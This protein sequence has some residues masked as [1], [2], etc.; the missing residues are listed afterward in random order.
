[1][2][3]KLSPMMQHYLQTKQQNPDALL[4][5]RL[6]DFYELFFEDAKIA[7]R[8]LELTLTGR[9]CGLEERA[10]MAGVPW[11]SADSYIG[12]LVSKGYKVAICEQVEDPKDAK[13]LVKRELVRIITPG[14]VTEQSQL[15][16]KIASYLYAVYF[17]KNACAL[18][19]CDVSTGEFFVREAKGKRAFH[20]LLQ[21]TRPKEI[22]TNHKQW[23]R[24]YIDV[25]TT[26]KEEGFF[27]L[28][29]CKK[30]L[31]QHFK[32][33][34]I[35]DIGLSS[36]NKNALI[37]AGAL[38]SYLQE[39]QKNSLSHITRLSLQE[40]DFAMPLDAATIRNLEL[41]EG[42]SGGK[43]S[44]LWVLDHCVTAMGA[45]MLRRMVEQPLVKKS[46]IDERL[47]AL[48]VFCDNF[49][50]LSELREDLKQ[51]YDLERLLS[52][53][54]Y[55]SFHARDCLSLKRSLYQVPKLREKISSMEV[56]G[57]QKICAA[58][59][60]HDALRDL[61][62][63][64]ID[65]DA[66]LAISEG[67]IIKDDFNA[68][69]KELR[70]ARKEGK[71]WLLALEEKEREASGIKN[72]KIQ[73]NRVFGYYFEISK[74]QIAKA[75]AH[76]IRRQT[77]V[78]A[79]R[80][81]SEALKQIEEKIS[82][83]VGR[84]VQIELSLFENIREE[85]LSHLPSLLDLADAIKQLDALLSLAF[86]ARSMGFVRPQINE[87]GELNIIGGRHPVVEKSLRDRSFV[88]N[89]TH[90]NGEDR[91]MLIITGPNMAGKSTYMRQTAL[92]V[93]MAHMG[94]FV[95][96][97]SADIPL[98]DR[99]F[100]RIGASDDL[101]SGQSTFMVEMSEL[102]EILK[103]AGP[104]SL[105][106]LDEIGRGTSTLD[107]LAIAWSTVEY[108]INKEKCGAKTM[109][110]THYHELSELENEIEGIKN[111]RVSIEELGEEVIFLH[112]IVSGGA[113]K[114]FGVYVAKLAGLPKAVIARAKEIQTRLEVGAFNQSSIAAGILEKGKKDVQLNLMDIGK[115]EF[116]EEIAQIDVLS[117]SP[118]EALNQLYVLREKA[119]RL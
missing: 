83:A 85:I 14:T 33:H 100:T 88:P 50:L 99:V 11:H 22:I 1:M 78:N 102:S 46:A 24:Q 116:V 3:P 97:E 63:R 115:S 81:T 57:I 49:V 108:I 10:P 106:V 28:S 101:A 80:Y 71:N 64:A 7:A 12:R 44:L 2:P 74:G 118:M 54:S 30:S 70:L 119:R 29:A 47:D 110:A 113:D 21:G 87:T 37:A 17:D 72:L 59:D 56:A 67:N 55:Q 98:T 41:L 52:R 68:E 73:Y 4:M 6:G 16:E 69:L 9:D 76:F 39:T 26:E 60:S 40:G 13:G 15:N 82:G 95:P 107:G 90:M 31:L 104:K 51:V 117:I 25:F 32:I 48:Q 53:L 96:A 114:S 66:P 91:R 34:A 27:A 42:L 61:I 79:E 111:Y 45:R 58:L 35:E 36:A 94:S 65:E 89:D 5:Y 18:A 112:K 19:G 38:L 20:I 103:H 109:F 62:E 86:A 105:V 43:S 75:P 84:M 23:V 77:L 8:E 92:I 93:L